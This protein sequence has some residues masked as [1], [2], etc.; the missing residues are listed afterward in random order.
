MEFG[1]SPRTE[2]LRARLL[3][4]MDD[5]VYPAEATFHAQLK[6]QSAQG[7]RSDPPV[8]V[9]LMAKAKAASLW[10]LF[11]PNE[12]W[13]AGLTNLEY[14]PLAEIM[15]RSVFLAPRVFNCSAPD[16]GNME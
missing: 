15:G 1:F 6:S 5:H 9:D 10:N 8:L 16:T 11:L 2:E 13:G 3:Q 12:K 7:D 14:A 4:F